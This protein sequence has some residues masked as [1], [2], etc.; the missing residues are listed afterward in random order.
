MARYVDVL[1]EAPVT[2]DG[3][4]IVAVRVM[5]RIGVDAKPT[6]HYMTAKGDW[7]GSVNEEQHLMVIPTDE[8]AVRQHWPNA[9][10]VTFDQEIPKEMQ[11]KD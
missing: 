5:D 10:M 9:N 2:L 8:V 4:M 6:I 11:K 7:L 1:P 3:K